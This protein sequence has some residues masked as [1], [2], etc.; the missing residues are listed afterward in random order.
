MRRPRPL[1]LTAAATVLIGA[2]LAGFLQ[3]A[4]GEFAITGRLPAREPIVGVAVIA[5]LMGIAAG[6][7]MASRRGWL[8]AV[9]LAALFA[10]VELAAAQR[11]EMLALGVAHA[12]AAVQLLA[13]RAW[14]EE[15]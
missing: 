11:P 5:Y 6:V 15:R 14:F 12:V 3:L 10:V 2:G 1:G 7:L 13:H 9:N 4:I 8:L